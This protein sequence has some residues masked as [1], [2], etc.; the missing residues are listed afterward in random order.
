MAARTLYYVADPMCSWC[1]GFAPVLEQVRERLAD[2]VALVDVMGGLAA[3]SDEP[4][5][6]EVRA[7]VQA[8]WDAVER[9]TGATFNRAFWSEQTARRSTYP[10]CR[11]VLAARLQREQAGHE[12]FVAIQR[13]YYRQA[14]NPSDLATLVEL[15]SELQPPLDT[16]R[17]EHDLT[18][19]AIER[20]LETEFGLRRMLRVDSFPSLVVAAPRDTDAP[21]IVMR[22]YEAAETLLPRLRAAEL[23]R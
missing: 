9:A 4:M 1:Y 6:A 17:F 22:G 23:I 20:A 16:E 8:A 12:M 14:R 18:S 10:A 15:G 5:P 13:A 11:A 3:D 7:Y 21:R 2:S 19:A